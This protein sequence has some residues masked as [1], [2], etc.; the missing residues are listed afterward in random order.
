MIEFPPQSA[1]AVVIP[2]AS[3]ITFRRAPASAGQGG[4]AGIEVLMLV[5]SASVRFAGAIVFPG[6]RVD[7]ADRELAAR[8]F[9]DHPDPVD[10]A[11]RIAGVRETLE[12]AG[13]ALGLSHA[14]SAGEAAT[15]RARL[16]ECGQLGTVLDEFGWTLD[17]GALIAFARWNPRLERAYDTRFY[18]A[19][20]GTGALALDVDGT[21]NN[22]LEWFAPAEVL[23]RAEAGELRAIFPTRCILQR[24]ALHA[25]FAAAAADAGAHPVKEI[26]P[27]IE[28]R[29]GVQWICIPEELGYP[30]T[31]AP[32]EDV[33]RA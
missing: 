28:W 8:L 26:V 23:A 5:R 13:L 30:Q 7:D 12:E 22:H 10:C 19:D 31:S 6:G 4:G 25:D 18:L 14:V 20:L 9:P 32:L 3:V 17:L 11:A 21:E 16:L 2:A 15:A 29:G 33:N 1:S 24:L 27:W